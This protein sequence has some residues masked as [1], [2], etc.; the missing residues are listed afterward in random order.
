[1]KLSFDRYEKYKNRLS[2][3][4]LLRTMIWGY[5]KKVIR[6]IWHWFHG[7]KY[8]KKWV[9]ILGCYN[10]G[11]T[12]LQRLLGSHPNISIL[13]R[14]GVIFTSELPRPEEYGW[15]RMWAMCQEKIVFEPK[16][17]RGKTRKIIEDWSPFFNANCD[18]FLE[19]SISNLPRAE[20]FNINFENAY[21]VGIR[22]NPYAVA[23]G[24]R[25]RAR[26]TAPVTKNYP[27]YYPINFAARQWL[28]ANMMLMEQAAKI[29]RYKICK[30]EAIVKDPASEL[31]D[32]FDFLDE[33][34]PQIDFTNNLLTIDTYSESIQNMNSSSINRLSDIDI[35]EI[36]SEIGTH[37]D[38]FTYATL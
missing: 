34:P 10:S 4:L 30:Y 7:P 26:P 16:K 25:R 32:I 27:E 17:E 33:D 14:E 37:I 11:T 8:P 31:R 2:R 6:E 38:K 28:V 29:E 24:I 9:F 15:T 3:E 18:V 12:L 13:P 1:M 20:W 21:F 22:R 19:K 35:K 5:R 36:N 23:E